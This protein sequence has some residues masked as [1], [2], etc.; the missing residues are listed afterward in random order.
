MTLLLDEGLASLVVASLPTGL[1]SLVMETSPIAAILA[2]DCQKYAP[3]NATCL[4][5]DQIRFGFVCS[6]RG[7]CRAPLATIIAFVARM[8]PAIAIM[9]LIA[10]TA[11]SSSINPGC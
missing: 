7:V 9:V 4:E 3:Q 5:R 2:P 1:F 10:K 11:G 6:L 8:S